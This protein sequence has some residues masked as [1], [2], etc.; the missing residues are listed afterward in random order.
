MLYK[1]TCKLTHPIQVFQGGIGRMN[2]RQ[3]L[4]DIVGPVL[5]VSTLGVCLPP[6]MAYIDLKFLGK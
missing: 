3:C 4:R 6:L 2:I 1:I 5:F